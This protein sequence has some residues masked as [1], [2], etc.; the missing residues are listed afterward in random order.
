MTMAQPGSWMKELESFL[1]TDIRKVA[2]ERQRE[3]F[4][5]DYMA[6]TGYAR[7]MAEAEWYRQLSPEEQRA[8][9]EAFWRKIDE[10][11]SRRTAAVLDFLMRGEYASAGF[12]Q[13]LAQ[14]DVLGALPAAW[15]GLTGQERITYGELAHQYLPENWPDWV[16]S[17]AGFLAGVLLDPT[18]WVGVGGLTRT[19][20]AAQA[21]GQLAPTLSARIAAGQQGLVTFAGRAPAP[22][23][24]SRVAQALE[25]LSQR[26]ADTRAVQELVEMFSTRPI[27]PAAKVEEIIRNREQIAR[28]L[29]SKARQENIAL[30]AAVADLERRMGVSPGTLEL[31]ITR[32]VE[33]ARPET[34]LKARRREITETVP[35]TETVMRQAEQ[36]RE[37]PRINPEYYEFWGLETPREVTVEEIQRGIME[38]LQWM[39]HELEQAIVEPGGISR[40]IDST[41][42]NAPELGDVV[43]RWGTVSTTPQW[44][45]EL[46]RSRSEVFEALEK[47]SGALYE[48]LVEIASE[49]MQKG[50]NEWITGS[51][52]PPR[53]IPERITET[54]EIP[55]Q[56]TRQVQR[57]RQVVE[58]VEV[59]WEL[60]MEYEIQ[61]GDTLSALARR[62]NTTVD[63]ILA[64][65]PQIEDPNVI[66][67][68]ERIRLPAPEEATQYIEDLRAEQVARLAR[69]RAA[70]VPTPEL[71]SSELEYFARIPTPQFEEY[72][73]RGRTKDAAEAGAEAA[74]GVPPELSALY[75]DVAEEVARELQRFQRLSV[76]HGSQIQRRLP[77]LPI[78]ELNRAHREGRLGFDKTTDSYFISDTPLPKN[79]RAFADFEGDLFETNPFIIDYV[80]EARSIRAIQAA[81]ALDEIRD[82]GMREGWVMQAPGELLEDGTF[83]VDVSQ[84]PEGWEIVQT[85]GLGDKFKDVIVRSDIAPHIRG[86]YQKATNTEELHWAL[87]VFDA[88]QNWWKAMTLSP[89]PAYHARN[90]AGNIWN[91][92]LADVAPRYYADAGLAMAGRKGELKIRSGPMAGQAIPYDEVMELAAMHGAIDTGFF[93]SEFAS[94]AL[95][96]VDDI[97]MA[98]AS[99]AF[100]EGRWGDALRQ[101]RQAVTPRTLLTRE[102]N[103]LH[104]QGLLVRGGRAVGNAIE[105]HARLA[106]FMDRLARGFTP[107]QAVRSVNTYLFDY[108]DVTRFESDV[109]R[110]LMPFYTWTRKNLPLQL[111]STLENPGKVVTPLK[112]ERDL[113]RLLGQET[114]DPEEIPD[115]IR[116]SFPIYMGRTS[117]GEDRWWTA[118][119]WWPWA[120]IFEPVEDP[121]QWAGGMLT[122][123]A[124]VPIEL[125]T[126]YDLYFRQP[127]VPPELH[128]AGETRLR[129]FLGMS[130]PSSTA[131]VLGQV[132]LLSELDRLNP[133]NVFGEDRPYRNDPDHAARWARFLTGM[134]LYEV[135]PWETAGYARLGERRVIEALQ[136]EAERARREGDD[137]GARY[138][139]ER[140]RKRLE[141][142][143]R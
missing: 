91:N 47:Q 117:E 53:F 126:N 32:E 99:Q 72:L 68:G 45:R 83:K 73:R 95:R 96:E 29:T 22:M 12:A 25:P 76:R 59:P 14:G 114:P 78:E 119:R 115:W 19:G 54:V 37:V 67:A 121:L 65:N 40:A 131:H 16:K 74:A 3:Q 84:I 142:L 116:E 11:R 9:H 106:H 41:Y 42:P 6:R 137:E 39:R 44:F 141:Q 92:H 130:M 135:D 51:W 18:T 36:I 24:Q 88:V 85:P 118:M 57:T 64:L 10:T 8:E 138:I 1:S 90:L 52:V 75:G 111:R 110:R 46:G 15:R 89:F 7:W 35:V 125:A 61:R 123:L 48:R 23:L 30:S 80:R 33:R 38:E 49:R 17:G 133:W 97:R 81:E 113:R 120:E 129:N 104:P 82:L 60:T 43:Y 70:G 101:Y 87:E 128:A 140:I 132:R 102:L 112:A 79:Q 105:N 77:E 4:I 143:R 71:Q 13:S 62:H 27:G 139:L 124:R 103:P 108:R 28:Y 55:E 109:M 34:M 5:Q 66:W 56:V 31:H 93:G 86:F 21:G 94:A 2:R 134:L 107:E 98:M 63:E 58:P 50:Y 20:R 69:E 100:R 26:I 122:P 127:I 136:R